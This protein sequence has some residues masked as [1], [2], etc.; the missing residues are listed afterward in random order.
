MPRNSRTEAIR[1]KRARATEAPAELQDG[2]IVKR[3]PRKFGRAI[4]ILAT[5]PAG[6]THGEW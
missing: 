2:L 4:T 6:V 3:M 1:R 5:V